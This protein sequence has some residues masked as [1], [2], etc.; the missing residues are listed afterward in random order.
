M[1]ECSRCQRFVYKHDECYEQ[2]PVV[3][4]DCTVKERDKIKEERARFQGRVGGLQR[5]NKKYKTEIEQLKKRVEGA[6]YAWLYLLSHTDR[7]LADKWN[8]KLHL[9]YDFNEEFCCGYCS[10]PVLGRYLFCDEVCEAKIK[11]NK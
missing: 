11:E 2:D 5:A 4:H 10:K 1:M 9:D 8:E 7:K 6:Q 3:C